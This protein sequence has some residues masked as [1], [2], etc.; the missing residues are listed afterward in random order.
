MKYVNSECEADLIPKWARENERRVNIQNID[1]LMKH[2]S[3]GE[4]L[5]GSNGAEQ[6]N[7][8]LEITCYL[9]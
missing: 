4:T 5:V 7:R 6:V 8:E 3:V 9:H 2:K 1:E